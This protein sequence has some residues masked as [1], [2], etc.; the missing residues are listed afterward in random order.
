MLT[1]SSASAANQDGTPNDGEFVFYYNSGCANALS[2]F[3]GSHKTLNGYVFLTS[4]PG[5]GQAVKNNSACGGN[6]NFNSNVRVYFNSYCQGINDLIPARQY[7]NFTNVYNE[8]ASFK[9]LA[10]SY[11]CAA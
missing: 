6:F 11:N 10:S 3:T 2:D 7:G 5:H 8:N 9:F 4:L 1:A